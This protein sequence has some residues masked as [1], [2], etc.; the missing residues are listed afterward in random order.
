MKTLSVHHICDPE[1]T[2]IIT[3]CNYT[4]TCPGCG[5]G[6]RVGMS[7]CE[8]CKTPVRFTFTRHEDVM[9]WLHAGE[10]VIPRRYEANPIAQPDPDC[11]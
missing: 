8:Y 10:G 4:D 11:R 9:A 2:H 7:H 1:P 3:E 6:Y 5:A